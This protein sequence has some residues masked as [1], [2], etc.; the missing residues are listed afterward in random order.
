MSMVS[1]PGHRPIRAGG[2]RPNREEIQRIR[3]E[4]NK[5]EKE[6][7]ARQNAEGLNL[8]SKVAIP[9]RTCRYKTVEEEKRARQDATT[10]QI[11]VFR[12]KL[13]VLHPGQPCEETWQEVAK[14]S[15][16]VVT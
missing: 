12:A 5:A 4:N 14:G 13:P 16:E 11:R 8:P 1:P 2:R 9:N 7:R 10:E 3:R 15:A 6:L